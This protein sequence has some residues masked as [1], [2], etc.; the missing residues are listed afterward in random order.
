LKEKEARPWEKIKGRL[1]KRE[2]EREV[3]HLLG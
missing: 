3:Q 2:E 1:G